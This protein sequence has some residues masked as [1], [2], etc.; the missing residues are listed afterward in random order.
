MLVTIACHHIKNN[1]I[2]CFSYFLISHKFLYYSLSPACQQFFLLARL[3]PAGPPSPHPRACARGLRFKDNLTS[4]AFYFIARRS[5]IPDPLPTLDSLQLIYH[6]W[7]WIR[8]QLLSCAG[9]PL[10]LA[11]WPSCT[12]IATCTIAVKIPQSQHLILD[13]SGAVPSISTIAT[14]P[15]CLIALIPDLETFGEFEILPEG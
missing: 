4:D 6:I 3:W 2:G 15:V 14:Y 7:Q 5:L 11:L 13:Q 10:I 9:G 12:S 8:D 1:L